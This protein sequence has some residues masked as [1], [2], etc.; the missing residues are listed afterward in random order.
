MITFG[1]KVLFFVLSL[2]GMSSHVDLTNLFLVFAISYLSKLSGLFSSWIILYAFGRVVG[3]Q[4]APMLFCVGNII[5]QG[6]F[7]LGTVF[8]FFQQYYFLPI[9]LQVWSLKWIPFSCP[10]LSA[11][12]CIT[13]MNI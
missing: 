1:V 8:F 3:Q 5:L 12:V 10:G 11:L 7:C 2:T 6:I 13:T 4:W 9:Y